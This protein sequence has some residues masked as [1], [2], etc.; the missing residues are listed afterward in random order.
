MYSQRSYSFSY[1]VLGRVFQAHESHKA[2]PATGIL[3]LLFGKGMIGRIGVA[4][5]KK[6]C[7]CDDSVTTGR[8]VL[9]QIQRHIQMPFLKHQ[10]GLRCMHR[11]IL[12]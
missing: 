11:H 1:S 9:Q 2:I 6:L 5:E 3:S 8:H 7:A 10:G 12:C 4:G